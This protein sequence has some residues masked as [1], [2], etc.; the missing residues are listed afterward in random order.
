ML[1]S[2]Y[3][4]ALM[5]HLICTPSALGPA[6]PW[7]SGVYIRQTTHAHSITIKYKIMLHPIS[8]QYTKCNLEVVNDSLF[9][10]IH[11]ATILIDCIDCPTSQ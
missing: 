3:A 2:S 8:L 7:A 1:H 10:Y 6:H 9:K 5:V 11:I 4:C